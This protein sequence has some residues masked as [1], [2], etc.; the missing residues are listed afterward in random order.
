MILRYKGAS[1]SKKMLP[2]GGPQGTLLGLFLFLILI[3]DVGFKDQMNDLGEISTCKRKL[4]EVNELHLKYVDDLALAEAVD[5]KSQ[6]TEVAVTDRPQPDTFH[7][8][9]GHELRPEN[10]RVY[11]QLQRTEEYAKVNKMKIN[12]KKTKLM[13][14]NPGSK[15]DFMPKFELGK[16]ELE[17]AEETTLLGV[18]MRSDLAWTSNTDYIVK[19]A[20]KKLWSLRRLKKLGANS[21]DLLDVYYK[22]VRSILEYAVPVW[23]PS[24]TS[25]DRL[26]IE[27]VQKAALSI[28]MGEGYQSYKTALRACNVE[29]LFSRRQNL[30]RKFAKKSLKHGKF[31]KWFKPNPKV[32][33]TRLKPTR[34]CKLYTR[35]ARYEK[36]PIGFLTNLL[37]NL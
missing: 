15:R 35:T 33:I 9:T 18:V 3:N 19:R 30:C 32:T 36:S 17:L 16:T 34:F 24:L 21:N 8:R 20:Y 11:L 14:F 26:K 23:H 28:I 25:D 7:A 12:G 10:S 4:R 13:L 2:G 22:Q 27:Q 6:L 29:T 1:S 37:N 31:S 5:L